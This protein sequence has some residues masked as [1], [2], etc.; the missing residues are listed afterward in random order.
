[1]HSATVH[2]EASD[3]A[4]LTACLARLT[5]FFAV[6]LAVVF[7]A[8]YH[9]IDLVAGTA[10]VIVIAWNIVTNPWTYAVLAFAAGAVKTMRVRNA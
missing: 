7:G 8:G 4:R 2:R 3:A 6:L 10:R 5:V 9:E 1:M